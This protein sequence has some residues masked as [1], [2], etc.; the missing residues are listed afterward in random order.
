LGVRRRKR[1]G[2]RTPSPLPILRLCSSNKMMSNCMSGVGYTLSHTHTLTHSHCHTYFHS[3]TVTLAFT[4][5]HTHTHTAKGNDLTS[6]TPVQGLF[7][8]L[9]V[10]SWSR[11]AHFHQSQHFISEFTRN[12]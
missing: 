2:R 3:L 12:S 6:I 8:K 4:H 10:V 1:K 11:N 5:T 9:S 7:V